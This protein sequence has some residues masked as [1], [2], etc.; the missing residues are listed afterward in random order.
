[1]TTFFIALL[2]PVIGLIQEQIP[3]LNMI[4]FDDTRFD[5][6]WDDIIDDLWP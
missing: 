6:T 2:L 3:W 5:I 4:D 1:M